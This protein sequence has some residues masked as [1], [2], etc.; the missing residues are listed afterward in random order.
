MAGGAAV[1][2]QVVIPMALLFLVSN[3]ASLLRAV[4]SPG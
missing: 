2:A 4:S 1:Q 3:R